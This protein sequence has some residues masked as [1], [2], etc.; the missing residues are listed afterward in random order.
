MR[1]L[2]VVTL[3][4]A[5]LLAA[6]CGGGGG[7][8]TTTATVSP[9]T[10]TTA[11]AAPTPTTTTAPAT[12]AKAIPDCQSAGMNA[13]KGRVGVCT[14]DGVTLTVADPGHEAKLRTLGVTLNG[15]RLAASVTD[16][17]GTRIAARGRFAICS[18]TVRNR[19]SAP[20][21]FDV[22]DR[23]QT[24]LVVDGTQVFERGDAEQRGD[25]R[26]LPRRRGALKPGASRTGDAIFDL[27]VRLLPGLR[28]N[29]NLFVFGTSGGNPSEGA[30]LHTTR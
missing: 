2:L 12:P 3:M 23:S 17:S 13:A 7:A 24:L 16:G 8:T 11:P 9:A 26:S 10:A 4:V 28:R 19:G 22:A 1:S 21:P 14:A 29:G 30:L 25:A 15:C 5:A 18:L 6:G 20:Q 27:P